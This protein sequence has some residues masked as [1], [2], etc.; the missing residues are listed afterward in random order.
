LLPSRR[1]NLKLLTNC[2]G[3]V[4]LDFAMTRNAGEFD[5]R[6]LTRWCASHLRGEKTT[7]TAHMPFKIVQ[8]H[9]SASSIGSRSAFGERFSS[10]SSRWHCSTSLSA[11]S[12]FALASSI[13]SPCEMA[14]GTSS[15]KQV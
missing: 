10:A 12:K 3:G 13:V 11:S 2:A 5:W 15:T 6:D 4:L 1:R 14:A 7:V 8:F 9:V